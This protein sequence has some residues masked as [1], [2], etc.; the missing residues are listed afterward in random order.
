MA[1]INLLPWRAQLRAERQRQA[2]VALLGVLVIAASVV[3]LAE[4]YLVVAVTQQQARN[5]FIQRELLLLD[6]RVN[7]I[8][9][10]KKQRQ[11]LVERMQV[12]QDLQGS[13]ASVVYVFDQLA[14]TLPSGVYFTS[15]QRTGPLIAIE[16]AAESNNLV[17]HLMRRQNSSDWLT[18]PKLIEVKAVRADQSDKASTFKLT[19]LQAVSSQSGRE[20]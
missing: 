10:L 20:L 19:V 13:R 15:L 4:Q 12:I 11:H 14:R 17:S 7:E 9:R 3:L 5:N 2:L 8:N 1:S 6:G 16:G 18:A